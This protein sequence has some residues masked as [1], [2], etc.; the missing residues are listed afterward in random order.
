MGRS[1]SLCALF[2]FMATKKYK[3]KPLLALGF[4]NLHKKY[5][6]KGLQK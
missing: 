4:S 5:I 6:A 1:F 3:P 2:S